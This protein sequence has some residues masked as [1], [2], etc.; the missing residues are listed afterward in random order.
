MTKFSRLLRTWQNLG[1]TTKFALSFALLLGMILLEAVVNLVALGDVRKAEDVI[2]NSV[3][4]RQRVFE[5]DG[6]LEKAGAC[7]GTF[8]CNTRT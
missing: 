4:I 1:I 2:L 3:E 8:F 7:T 5:M 6:E